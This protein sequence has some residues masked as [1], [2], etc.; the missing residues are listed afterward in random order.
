MKNALTIITYVSGFLLMISGIL[1][2]IYDDLIFDKSVISGNA[3][4]IFLIVS[5]VNLAVFLVCIFV[6]KK[7]GW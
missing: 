2:F 6:S 3:F 1:A 5:I 7:K 4:D